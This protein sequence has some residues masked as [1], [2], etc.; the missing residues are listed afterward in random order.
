MCPVV[1]VT[2]PSLTTTGG[3]LNVETVVATKPR[4]QPNSISLTV[5]RV[6]S[7]GENIIFIPLGSETDG[8]GYR[9]PTTMNNYS[10]FHSIAVPW[11][12]SAA[13]LLRVTI[14][15]T[16]IQRGAQECGT[17]GQVFDETVRVVK[18][19]RS[20]NYA[21]V[22]LLLLLLLLMVRLSLQF[23]ISLLFFYFLNFISS[24]KLC[25]ECIVMSLNYIDECLVKTVIGLAM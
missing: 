8:V 15:T 16:G 9:V 4:P 22:Y 24:V 2:I 5:T 10:F 6:V 19:M 20:L 25:R 12:F 1:D 11:N 7:D 3:T 21:F 17:A 13:D 18:G 14:D 23:C